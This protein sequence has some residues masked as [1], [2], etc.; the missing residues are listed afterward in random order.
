MHSP[1]VVRQF[2]A[3]PENVSQSLPVLSP[4]LDGTPKVVGIAQLRS[5]YFKNQID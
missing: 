1:T 4:A 2:A 3:S 5:F